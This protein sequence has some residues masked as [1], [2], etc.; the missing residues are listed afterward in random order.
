L[1]EDRARPLL[2]GL[3]DEYSTRYGANDEMVAYP[4]FSFKPPHGQAVLIEYQDSIVAGG[5]V[6][7]LGP[8][9]GEI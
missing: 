2:D 7:A 3:F 8:Q 1:T 9:T 6:R 4:S 5:A